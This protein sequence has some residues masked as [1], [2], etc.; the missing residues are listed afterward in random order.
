MDPWYEGII[1]YLQTLKF[2]T[3]LSWDKRRQLH[4]VAE[5]YLIVDDTLYRHVVDSILFHCLTHEEDE[6]MHNDSTE[7]HV[8]V[9]YL[10][11]LKPKFF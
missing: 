3:H 7:G 6:V 10:D 11:F 8:V 2:P 9:I 5:N 1:I 4:H